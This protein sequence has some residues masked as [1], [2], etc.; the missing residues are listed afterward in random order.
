MMPTAVPAAETLRLGS[1]YGDHMVLQ[2]EM[3][4][5]I[6]GWAEPGATVEVTFAGQAAKAEACEKGCWKVAL[7][8]MKASATGR[9][10]VVRGGEQTLKL[11]DV[12]VGEVWICSGQSNM[13]WKLADSLNA[14]DEIAAA[15]YPEIRMFDVPKGIAKPT[16]Q[17]TVPG[18]WKACQPGTVGRFS[19]VAYFFGRR[20]HKEL[21]VP[22]GLIGTYFGGTRIEP[23]IPPSG[24]A[25]VPEL[26]NYVEKLKQL[27][28]TTPEGKEYLRSYVDQF[29][30]W[31]D[32]AHAAIDK[33][34]KWLPAKPRQLSHKDIDGA[35]VFYN[36]MVHALT[37]LAARGAIWY[38][39]ESNLGEGESY[40]HKMQALIAGWRNVFAN[41][42][43]GFYFVQLANFRSKGPTDDPAGGDEWAPTREAQRK[44]L[45]VPHTGMAVITDIGELNNIHPK[46]KQDVGSRLAQYALNQTYD[47][48]DL[49]PSG[50]LYKSHK[51]E[52]GAIRVSFEFV[53]E[54]L[55]AGKKQGLEPVQELSGG[56]L[57]RWAIAGADKVWHWATAKIDGPC[58]V[59]SSDS[60]KEPVA[61]RYAY[62][63]NPIGA[64]LYNKAG[65]PASPFRT[66]DW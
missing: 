13:G 61:V 66:D 49:V 54:G 38:Q 47:R 40:F 29:K 24:F 14:N 8:P 15:N 31:M 36:G 16:P 4:A 53:G 17:D 57:E 59:V 64:N 55:I 3:P 22:V 52:E 34:A 39:G 27:D 48:D 60:V 50:P 43:L 42:D 7:K 44:T 5:V 62:S 6:R 65:L 58:V 23:W 32:K 63:M 10:L 37:P 11:G 28:P 26:S 18:E 51:V 45:A 56:K 20:L 41:D 21:N 33:G 1:I 35:T 46:N 30:P 19:A 9:E 12:L 2:R 25:A